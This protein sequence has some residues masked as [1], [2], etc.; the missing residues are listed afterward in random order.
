MHVN[1]DYYITLSKNIRWCNKVP[2]RIKKTA[3]RINLENPAGYVH[4]TSGYRLISVTIEGKSKMIYAHNFRWF[5]EYDCLPEP[6]LTIDHKDND[7]YNNELSNLRLATESQQKLNRSKRKGC[8]SKYYGVS[9]HVRDNIW[10]AEIWHNSKPERVYYGP[11]EIDAA[12]A[13]DKAVDK[14]FPKCE[15]HRR[16]FPK[17]QL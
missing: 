9:W 1:I 16:N 3:N 17:E 12:Q 2:Y 13:Y 15:F 14:Y 11:S 6:P 4:K 10:T 8:S 7:G 5:M